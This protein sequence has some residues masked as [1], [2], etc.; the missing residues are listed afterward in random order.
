ML[1][2]DPRQADALVGMCLVALASRQTEAAIN[3]ALAATNA[4]PRMGAA[5][6]ALGQAYKAGERYADAEAAYECAIGIS[7]MN[8][9]ARLGLGELR[10]AAGRAE[11]AIDEFERALKLQPMLVAAQLGVGN[12]LAMLGRN[13]EALARYRAALELRPRLPEGEFAAGFVLEPCWVDRRG[14]GRGRVAG[15]RRL[16][17]RHLMRGGAGGCGL[18]AE[19]ALVIGRTMLL[20]LRAQPLSR[21]RRLALE[22]PDVALVNRDHSQRRGGHD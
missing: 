22:L 11:E 14:P 8:A 18:R 9:L 5:W 10:I 19:H 4:A 13:E 6:V 21:D 1:E 7:G 3:M 2:R 12:A 16:H 15:G 17:V 20:D